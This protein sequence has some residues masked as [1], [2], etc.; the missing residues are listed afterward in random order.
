MNPRHITPERRA[1]AVADYRTSGDT[2][3]AVS[4]RHGVSAAALNS[5]VNGMTNRPRKNYA[6]CDGLTDG[7]WVYCPLRRVQVWEAAA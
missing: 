2:Y 6:E 7:R 4:K 3:A 5:W 1:A